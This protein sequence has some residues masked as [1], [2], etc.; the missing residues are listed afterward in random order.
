MM[1]RNAWSDDRSDQGI[2]VLAN[3]KP[4]ELSRAPDT[5]VAGGRAEFLPLVPKEP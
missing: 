3:R 4:S 2:N 5:R 1:R